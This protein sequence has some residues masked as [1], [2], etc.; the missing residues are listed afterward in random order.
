MKAK[1]LGYICVRLEER[2]RK[3]SKNIMNDT[4]KKNSGQRTR[5]HDTPKH[6]GQ[7]SKRH[8][9]EKKNQDIIG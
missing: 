4:Q 7:G 3:I 2:R 6:F 1:K 8:F 9:R 5:R